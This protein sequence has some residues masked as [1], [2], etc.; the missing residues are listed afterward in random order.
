MVT[1]SVSSPVNAYTL[2]ACSSELGMI[3]LCMGYRLVGAGCQKVLPV[4]GSSSSKIKVRTQKTLALPNDQKT[5]LGRNREIFIS[6]E[7]KRI[8][9]SLMKSI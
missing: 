4:A 9:V 5:S 7:V 1:T 8:D 6:H 2:A 3:L